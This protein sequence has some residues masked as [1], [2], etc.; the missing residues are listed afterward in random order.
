MAN[1]SPRSI[2]GSLS[3]VIDLVA[4]LPNSGPLAEVLKI[5]QSEI[6]SPKPEPVAT[7]TSGLNYAVSSLV[8]F[9]DRSACASLRILPGR[10]RRGQDAD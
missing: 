7:S 4:A 8:G 2:Y 5:V 1:E 10:S 9:T 6:D 3:Q